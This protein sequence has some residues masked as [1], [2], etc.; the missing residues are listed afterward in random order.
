MIYPMPRRTLP[1]SSLWFQ[2]AILT[3]LVGFT[4]LGILAYLTYRDQPPIPQRVV[5][6]SGETL[7]TRDDILDGMNVFQRYGVMEYGSIYGHGAYLG[8]DFTAEYLHRRPCSSHDNTSARPFR[9][10][11]PGSGSAA[12]LH[13]NAYDASNSTLPWSAERAAAHNHMVDY[14]RHRIPQP[15]EP[16]GK[17]G[18]VDHGPGGCPQAHRVL[19]LDLLDRHGEP[20]G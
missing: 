3:Y 12:E 8:P 11:P 6:E 13:Q 2:G 10:H 15:R 20:A 5:A 9:A 7:F 19:C 1:I 18:G 16:G 17:A 14:Y 4:I